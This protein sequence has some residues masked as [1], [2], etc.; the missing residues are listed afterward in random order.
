MRI[1]CPAFTPL[2]SGMRPIYPDADTAALLDQMFALLLR[3]SC[4]K[5]AASTG[6]STAGS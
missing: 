6:A 3:L 4:A 1:E 5:N 2:P